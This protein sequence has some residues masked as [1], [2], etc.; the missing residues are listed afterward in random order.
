MEAGLAIS[1]WILAVISVASALAVVLVRDI[2]RAALFLVLCFVALA[3]I[4]ITLQADFLAAVQ[5]LIYAG[6][7]A[8]LIIFAVMLT[9][10]VARGN[11]SNPL[12]FSALVIAGLF[13]IA[14]IYVML[15]TP[16]KLSPEAP[17]QP[18]TA[19]IADALFTRFLLPFELASV[20]LVAALIGAIVLAREK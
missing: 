9:R 19:G 15:N 13:L 3:G 2:F 5:I 14:L 18:T 6:A 7:I 11:P 8:I 10:D 1:F 17:T 20:L 4:Y 16:W 12:R